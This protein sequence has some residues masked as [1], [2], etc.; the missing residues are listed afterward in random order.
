MTSDK[1]QISICIVGNCQAQSIEAWVG[2]DAVRVRILPIP[3]VWLIEPIHEFDIVQK[4]EAADYIFC[5]RLSDDFNIEYLRPKLLK[6]KYGHKLRTWP[7][8]YF[9]GYFPGIC[10]RYR[11]NGTKISGPIDDYHFDTYCGYHPIQCLNNLW[12]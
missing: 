1:D 8:I 3:P 10:Y 9:D 11:S 4:L 5:Q 7:N 6:L 2:M 12:K